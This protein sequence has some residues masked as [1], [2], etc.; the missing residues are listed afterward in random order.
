MNGSNGNMMDLPDE[1]ILA[2]WNR[3]TKTDVLYS[4]VGVNKRLNQLVRDVMY[5]RSIE[6]LKLRSKNADFSFTDSIMDRFC[7]DILPQI[8]ELVECLTVESFSMERIL[9]AGEFP[10]LRNLTLV[11]VD[12]QFVPQ[13]FT[14]M[15]ICLT[16]S[17]ENFVN[18]FR[19]VT[20]CSHL[21]KADLSSNG[22]AR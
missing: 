5:T 19:R 20:V 10:H 1:M 7:L 22:F 11:E 15:R 14:G 6:L 3:L 13:N 2:I 18:L 8:H 16:F 9:F 17:Y 21:Q 4:F 12:Q